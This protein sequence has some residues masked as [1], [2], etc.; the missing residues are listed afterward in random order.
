[1][2]PSSI[3]PRW[4][5]AASR[6]EPALVVESLSQ[7][8]HPPIEHSLSAY[9]NEVTSG[10]VSVLTGD[11][12]LTSK[13]PHFCK[14]PNLLCNVPAME[15][16]GQKRPP[17][18]RLWSVGL[19]FAPCEQTIPWQTNERTDEWTGADPVLSATPPT[20]EGV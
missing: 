7:S 19:F 18:R 12:Q 1:M 20:Q 6:K 16:M 17:F 14:T 13:T 5:L 3:T 2:S 15:T 10:D 9:Q 8:A 11:K 4:T